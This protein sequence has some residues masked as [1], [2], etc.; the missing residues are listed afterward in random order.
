MNSNID[1]LQQIIN[2]VKEQTD[3]DIENIRTKLASADKCCHNDEDQ[4]E[5]SSFFD[6]ILNTN[7][8]TK[9]HTNTKTDNITN[10]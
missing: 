3:H 5:G 7:A 10:S 8:N 6:E 9:H 4:S 2:D 1:D